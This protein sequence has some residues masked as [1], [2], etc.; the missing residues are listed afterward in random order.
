MSAVHIPKNVH[1]GIDSIYRS[2]AYRRTHAGYTSRQSCCTQGWTPSVINRLT[3]VVCRTKLTTL[4]TVDVPW[5]NFSE[6]RI[7]DKVP[8][9]DNLIFVEIL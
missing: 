3:T 4:A 2:V 1:A 6:S 7:W 5:P 9:G 8:A